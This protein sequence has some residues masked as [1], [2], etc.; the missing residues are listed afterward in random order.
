[1]AQC[2][3]GVKKFLQEKTAEYSTDAW[4]EEIVG[5]KLMT[6]FALI[7]IVPAIPKHLL[8]RYETFQYRLHCDHKRGRCMNFSSQEILQAL[9]TE[10]PGFEFSGWS[11][12]EYYN[13]YID[14]KI[15]P[16]K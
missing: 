14:I 3:D 10:F 1:M 6:Q 15:I 5:K 4:N 11:S 8:I 2:P 13:C 16:P 9:R 12:N 7:Q